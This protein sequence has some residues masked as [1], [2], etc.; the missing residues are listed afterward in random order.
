[1]LVWKDEYSIGVELIDA[2]HQRLFEIGNDI[3][4]LLENYLLDD[5]YDKIMVI[6]QELKDYTKYHFKTEEEYMMQIKYPKFFSQKVA[7]DDFIN[8]IEEFELQDI[9]Q[10][11][12]K[13]I[14]EL[15]EFVFTWI[16]EHIV[17]QDKLIT[18]SDQ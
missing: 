14:R 12:E 3:Y 17:R 13:Y 8:K 10:D 5:K 1:M 4:N 15:L 6:I 11:Q 16:L 2:Q 9:D 7:H 18:S